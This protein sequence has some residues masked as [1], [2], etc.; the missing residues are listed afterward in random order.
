MF[1]VGRWIRIF[2]PEF[3]FAG[4]MCIVGVNNSK[5]NNGEWL[6]GLTVKNYLPLLGEV[7][8][9][10]EEVTDEDNTDSDNESTIE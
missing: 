7:Q 4:D 5:N 8:E 1:R 6:T 10:E 3:G 2:N 9:T